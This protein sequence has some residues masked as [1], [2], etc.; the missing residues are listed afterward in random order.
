MA[1]TID[2]GA[3]M[4][5]DQLPVYSNIGRGIAGNSS[6]VELKSDGDRTILQGSIFDQA[7]GSWTPS[8]ETKNI[9]GGK[10][11]CTFNNDTPSQGMFTITFTYQKLDYP[12]DCW[13]FTTPGIPYLDPVN[14]V[15]SQA[16]LAEINRINQEIIKLK[17]ELG[18]D[19]DDMTN[20]EID[21][22]FDGEEA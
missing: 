5:G 18:L 17:Q 10:L 7:T 4:C 12:D 11:T 13:T 21:D 2:R 22:M 19:Y 16:Y 15:T 6:K 20:D 3:D 9:N 1:Y 14:F 8:W